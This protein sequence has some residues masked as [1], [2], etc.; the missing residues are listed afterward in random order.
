[1]KR[2]RIG[3]LVAAT[4][5]ISAV[6]LSYPWFSRG[7]ELLRADWQN[8]WAL[9]GLLVLPLVFWRGTFGEDRRTPRLLMGTLM[10]FRSGPS[11]W[12]V[13]LRDI[14]GT[15]R[16]IGLGLLVAALARP[17]NTM[18]PQTAR[19]EGIDIVV[20]FDLSGSMRAAMENLPENLHPYVPRRMKGVRPTR[21]DAARAVLRDFISRRKTD[22]IGVV[23]FAVDAYVLSPPTLDYHLLDSLV[24]RMDLELIDP[25]GTA[26]GDAIGVAVARLRR[27]HARSKA[28][29]VLTDGDN[30]GGRIAPEYGAHLANLVGVKLFPIQIGQGETAEVQEGVDL[31]GQPRYISYPFPTNPALLRELANKTNGQ[32][33]VATDAAALQAS[34]HDVLDTL[35]KTQ[36][37]AGVASYEE[38]YGFLLLPGVLL[39]A[40]EALLRSLL[41]RR[42]P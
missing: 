27:S 7:E 1:V 21:L 41:L 32:M 19:E 37:E 30:K 9:L 5:L 8:A 11:G 26:I 6:A 39:V 18:R 34:F 2:W 12:R 14:P 17:V 33:Y 28:V 29:I 4:L 22:R 35:E 10:P 15:V 31:F 20:A 40:L 25:G 13:W 38:L 23:V 24:S 42:F 16:T 36:F 3:I